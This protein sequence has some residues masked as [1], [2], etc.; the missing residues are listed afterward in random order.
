M[1]TVDFSRLPA[2]VNRAYYPY[3]ND[4]RRYQVFKGG[5][6]AG[7]SVFVAQKITYQTVLRKGFNTLCLRKVGRDNHDSTFAELCKCISAWGL[8]DLFD[9]NRSRG[10]EEIV[11]K[12]NGNKIIFRGL[13]NVEKVKSV[14]FATGDLVCVWFEEASEGELADLRQL[15][16]RLRGAG[17]PVPKHLLLSFNPIDIG[18]WLKTE[19]FDRSLDPGRGYVLET[20]YLD[21][22]FL[23]DEYRR[24]LLALEGIDAYYYKVYVLNE[25]GSLASARVFNNLVIE[26]FNPS[27]V[28]QP[29]LRY[30]VDFGFNHASAYEGTWLRD[31][32][33]YVY[34]EAYGRQLLN[35]DFIELV[36]AKHGLA[37]P[38]TCDSA[39]P[40]LIQEFVAA[41]FKAHGAAK[42]PDSLARGINWLRALKKIHIHAT[43]CPNA[44]REFPRLKYR[45]LRDGS[46]TEQV[47]ELDDDTVAAV[48][49]ANEDLVRNVAAGHF[50]LRKR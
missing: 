11:C 32:E 43:N 20:T 12:L 37:W 42:G 44:A 19:F 2:L 33:L 47:V 35:R 46:I 14:T 25:W 34:R 3:L 50:I 15:N 5:A 31:G 48:R 38:L 9:V 4:F 10:A 26:E 22:R 17:G 30:G 28:N 7:K 45:E 16:L 18:S 39:S 27:D 29:N 24:E 21:N 40:G 13:D 41:G 36:R 6:G 8:E 1:T 49:Y 23:D